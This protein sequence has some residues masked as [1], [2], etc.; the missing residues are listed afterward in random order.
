MLSE[1]RREAV[2]RYIE[3]RIFIFLLVTLIFI[4]GIIGGAVAVNGL[5][6]GQKLELA[7]Y[8][9]LFFQGFKQ[10]S[11]PAVDFVPAGRIVLSHLKTLFLL[12]LFG[13]SVIGAPVILFIVFTKGFILGFTAGF[14]LEQWAGRGFLFV[15]ASL[16]PHHILIVPAVLIAAVANIDFAGALLKGRWGKMVPYPLT[17]ELLRCLGLNGASFLLLLIAGLVEGVLS[18]YLIYWVAQLF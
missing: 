8:L 10:E 15:I 2:I 6:E 16:I 11:R 12:F 7:Q 13:F 5:R 18:P 17:G 4:T 9:H 1:Y 14:I 3:D